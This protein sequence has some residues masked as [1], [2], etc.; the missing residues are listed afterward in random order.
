MFQLFLIFNK[1]ILLAGFDDDYTLS[2]DDEEAL[3]FI[4]HSYPSAT[5]VEI[6]NVPL[7]VEKLKPH[8][9]NAWLFGDV[10]FYDST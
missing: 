1:V 5:V 8:T 7:T 6:D 4:R 2:Q 9:S 3:E 10:S